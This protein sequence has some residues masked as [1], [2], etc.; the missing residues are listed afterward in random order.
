MGASVYPSSL[1]GSLRPLTSLRPLYLKPRTIRTRV[2]RSGIWLTPTA[3][4]DRLR[5]DRRAGAAGDDQ[6]RPAEEEFVDAVPGAILRQ[7][8]EIK[9]FA[10]AQSHGRN[11]HPVPG[12]VRFRGLVRPH[13]DAPGIRA[14]GGDLFVLAPVAIL[15]PDAGRVAAGV[16]APFLLLEAALHLSGANDDE[17]AAADL[18]LLLL[19]APVELV[20]GNA[21]A[22]LEPVDAAETRDVEQHAA[23]HHLVLGMLDAQHVQPF[24]VDELGVVAVVGLVLVE[25]VPERIPVRSPLHA[26]VQRVVGVADLVPVLSAGDGVG[27]G[28]QHLM[29]RIEASS[30]QARLRAVAVERDAEREHLAGADQTSRLDDILRPDLVERADLVVLAPAPPILELLRSLGNRLLA[31]LDVHV[32]RPLITLLQTAWK[33]H[34]RVDSLIRPSACKIRPGV[35]GMCVSGLAPSGRS[36]SLMAFMTAPGAPA[37]PASPAPLA[38][39]SESAVGVTTW[40]TSMSGISAAIGTR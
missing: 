12:L 40:P 16:A 30:K 38:P 4:L 8:L 14:D 29:D 10:H 9:D 20:V 5:I 22:V 21:F 1:P 27:A 36:A 7:I 19:G 23:P 39:S 35:N 11:H 34:A 28:R 37:V 6:R 17:V 31:H 13:L 2:C 3:S 26:Q 18:D 32:P 24:G 25:D 15:E 33:H